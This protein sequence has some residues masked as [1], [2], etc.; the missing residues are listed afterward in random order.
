MERQYLV[1]GPCCWGKGAT[2]KEALANAR[3]ARVRYAEGSLGWRYIVFDVHPS[4]T[5]DEMGSLCYIPAELDGE[6]PYRE[7]RRVGRFS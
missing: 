5:V 6:V 2:E 7:V 3:K 4:V 1:M